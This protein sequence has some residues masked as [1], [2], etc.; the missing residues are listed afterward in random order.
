MKEGAKVHV[1]KTEATRSR[2]QTR[3]TQTLD[4]MSHIIIPEGGH[5]S[6]AIDLIAVKIADIIRERGRRRAPQTG[7]R[8]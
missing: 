6:V 1:G 4:A 5:N 2:I 3:E 8:P 7:G